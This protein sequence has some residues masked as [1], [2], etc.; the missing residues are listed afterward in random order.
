MWQ[1]IKAHMLQLVCDVKVGLE[2]RQYCVVRALVNY[3]HTEDI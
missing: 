3:P 1:N 2:D